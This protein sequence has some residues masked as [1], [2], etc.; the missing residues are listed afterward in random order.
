MAQ[1]IK[2]LIAQIQNEGVKVAE[3]KARQIKIEAQAEAQDLI[4]Q[5]KLQAQNIVE[6]ASLEAKK[7][8]VSTQVLLKQSGRD[9]VISLR[10]EINVL[11][12][13]LIKAETGKFL[14]PEE[15]QR[16]I[17]T[18][19]I[20]APLTLGGEVV[21]TLNPADKEKLTQ[22]FLKQLS[23]QTKRGIVLKSAEDIARG[24][25]ISF[26]AGKSIFDFSEQSLTEYIAKTMHPELAKIL[27]PD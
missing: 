24:F 26:D 23:A 18:L 3:E 15:M 10:A 19:V 27:A 14:T 16:I 13:R 6:E 2:D 7:I 20:N 8:S 17:E 1:E 12:Q 5:A 9:L 4:A 25:I 11:L 22:D 21:I